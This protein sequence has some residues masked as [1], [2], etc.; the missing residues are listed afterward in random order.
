MPHPTIVSAYNGYLEV[1]VVD[2]IS[3]EAK[4]HVVLCHH[5]LHR[6]ERQT[7]LGDGQKGNQVAA[8]RCYGNDAIHPPEA[9]EE[10]TG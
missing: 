10:A 1:F 9:D 7:L 3:H 6:L 8:E 5:L 2:C 4:L